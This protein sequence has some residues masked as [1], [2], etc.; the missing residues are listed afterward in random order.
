MTSDLIS[1]QQHERSTK[2]Y[3]N[4]N[5]FD[6]VQSMIFS[7]RKTNK[8]EFAHLRVITWSKD[9]DCLSCCDRNR[10]VPIV[11]LHVNVWTPEDCPSKLTSFAAVIVSVDVWLLELSDPSSKLYSPDV[12]VAGAQV[13]PVIWSGISPKTQDIT[14]FSRVI[15]SFVDGVILAAEKVHGSVFLSSPTIKSLLQQILR[16]NLTKA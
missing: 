8:R 6:V 7:V 9:C 1:M 13:T 12:S 14:W 3:V 16:G 10:V 2:Y 11:K 15:T 5:N 4:I